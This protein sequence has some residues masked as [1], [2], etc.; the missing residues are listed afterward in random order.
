VQAFFPVVA[1][2]EVTHRFTA[3]PLTAGSST[4]AADVVAGSTWTLRTVYASGS[5]ATSPHTGAPMLTHAS[6]APSAFDAYRVNQLAWELHNA[7]GFQL[8][9]GASPGHLRLYLHL[10]RFHHHPCH[11]A[12]CI[13]PCL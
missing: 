10:R 12:H 8:L 11:Q 7:N 4:S 5:A 9:P 2:S 1:C 6:A 13:C 3:A